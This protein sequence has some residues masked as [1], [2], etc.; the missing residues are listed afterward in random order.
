MTLGDSSVTSEFHS[1]S[2]IV[3]S[4]ALFKEKCQILQIVKYSFQELGSYCKSFEQELSNTLGKYDCLLATDE[5]LKYTSK[6][7]IER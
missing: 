4:V 6:A 7:Y 1:L 5:D 2:L 3:M